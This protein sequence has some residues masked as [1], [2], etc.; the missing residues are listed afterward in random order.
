MEHREAAMDEDC[1]GRVR[2]DSPKDSP[3]DSPMVDKSFRYSCCVDLLKI[4]EFRR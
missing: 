2:E 1:S 3:K 4:T